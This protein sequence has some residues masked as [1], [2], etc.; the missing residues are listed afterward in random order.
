MPN[1]CHFSRV[2]SKDSGQLSFSKPS[3]SSQPQWGLSQHSLLFYLR[4]SVLGLGTKDPLPALCLSS[5]SSKA[6]GRGTREL[7]QLSLTLTPCC[8]IGT[9]SLDQPGSGDKLDRPG[10]DFLCGSCSLSLSF[11][12]NEMEI[13]ICVSYMHED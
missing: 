1:L 11:T 2:L 9:Q 4:G 5:Q 8:V 12:S 3:L 6:G 10:M 7:S 13:S